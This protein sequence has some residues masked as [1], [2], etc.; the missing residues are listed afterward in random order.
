MTDVTVGHFFLAPSC[1]LNLLANLNA[2]NGVC[3]DD[4][5]FSIRLR[6]ETRS[7]VSAAVLFVFCRRKGEMSIAC[8]SGH[9]D[10]W[11]DTRRFYASGTP[12]A[13]ISTSAR[14]ANNCA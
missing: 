11:I 6:L 12:H 10:I 8:Q 14:S 7:S 2:A 13:F 3:S 4:D 5:A 1:S 9:I